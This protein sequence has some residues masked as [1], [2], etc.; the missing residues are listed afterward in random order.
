MKTKP[1][2]I[3]EKILANYSYFS[4]AAMAFTAFGAIAP[5]SALMWEKQG[6]PFVYYSLAFLVIGIIFG[7]I[8]NRLKNEQRK[9]QK[10]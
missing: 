8:L 6:W 1:S 4:G 3:K 10:R 2:T 9:R 5:I 7:I